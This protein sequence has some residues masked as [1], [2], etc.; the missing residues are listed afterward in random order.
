MGAVNPDGKKV[1]ALTTTRATKKT[2]NIKAGRI[3]CRK[4]AIITVVL[5][6]KSTS[7]ILTKMSIL[8]P[9]IKRIFRLT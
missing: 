4:I 9:V 2:N 1:R 6:K 8:L 7:P 3:Y 5:L